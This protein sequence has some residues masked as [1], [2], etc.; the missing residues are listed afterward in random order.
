MQNQVQ[1][2]RFFDYLDQCAMEAYEKLNSP[3]LEGLNLALEF[4]L[5]DEIPEE[6]M[7]SFE[8]YLNAVKD[9]TF[10]PN[11]VRKAIQL[12][13]LKGLKSQNLSNAHMTPDT[14]GI[15]LAYFIKRFIQKEYI[16]ILDPFV[17]TG[18]L[19]STIALNLNNVSQ[20]IGVDIDP[21]YAR[22]ARNM[23]DI[24]GLNTQIFEQ[25]INTFQGTQFDV[26]IGD[27]DATNGL[28]E[29]VNHLLDLLNGHGYCFLLINDDF[30]EQDND[31]YFYSQYIKKAHVIGLI[32]LPTTTLKEQSKHI[33]I[34]QKRK[35]ND[36]EIKKALMVNLPSFNDQES[37][38]DVLYSIDQWILEREA[39]T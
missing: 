16:K 12:A 6:L 9:L 34:F 38:E 18:N 19:L 25:P 28:L 33:I 3:Y 35:E 31:R 14:I 7:E 10:D 22:L 8:D 15:L 30:F 11:V 1:I 26:I 2:N 20:M 36:A 17:G 27:T 5:D 13:I 32:Q 37:F 21:F 24:L 29:D 23:S 39:T 4:F